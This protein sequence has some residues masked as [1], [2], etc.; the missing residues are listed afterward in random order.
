MT[1]DEAILRLLEECYSIQE[2]RA[3]DRVENL[4]KGLYPIVGDW[5]L[6]PIKDSPH[7]WAIRVAWKTRSIEF[8]CAEIWLERVE[9]GVEGHVKFINVNDFY[10]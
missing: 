5:G 10:K 7:I 1:K 3:M 8:V 6:M 9:G 2:K 4:M